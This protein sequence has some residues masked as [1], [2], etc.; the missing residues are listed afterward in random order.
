MR[1]GF[2]GIATALLSCTALAQASETSAPGDWATYGHDKGAQRHSPLT[3]ITPVNV[4]QLAPAWVYHMRPAAPVASADAN[5]NA[6]AEA[7]RRAEGLPHQARRIWPPAARPSAPRARRSRFAGSEVTP[8][9]VG[10]RMFVSTPYGRVVALNPETGAE[11]WATTIPGTGQPSL[12]GVE[13]WPGDGQTPPRIFFG[14]RD[15]RLIA[16][17]AATGA[18]AEGFGQH[19][20]VEMKTPEILNGNDARFYGM[21]S[22]PIV[23][24]HL[25]ITGSAVQEFPAKGAA[26]D[27]RAWDA[28]D[29]HLIWTFHSVPRRGEKGYDT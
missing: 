19:G 24:G 2:V 16:L 18:F 13:Y 29:G 25:I 6:N 23:Y 15:G 28:R 11:L 5:A 1:L 10:G 22:P 26:G 7:Q 3:E 8:L 4:G 21:T 17:D 27:V 9:V 20:V 14:T 12:R